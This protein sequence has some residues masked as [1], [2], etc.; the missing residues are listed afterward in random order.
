MFNPAGHLLPPLFWVIL[1]E[2]QPSELPELWSQPAWVLTLPLIAWAGDLA[3]L[4]LSFLTCN[5]D[6][7][8]VPASLYCYE[9]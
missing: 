9:D 7:I 6:M 8:I 5:M 4:S 3:D 1:L 2:K